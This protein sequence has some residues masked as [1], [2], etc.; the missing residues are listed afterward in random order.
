MADERVIEE[1]DAKTKGRP[2]RDKTGKSGPLLAPH[3]LDYLRRY[4]TLRQHHLDVTVLDGMPDIA[5]RSSDD[6]AL[7]AASMLP[8]SKTHVFVRAT[9]GVDI[10]ADKELAVLPEGHHSLVQYRL[11]EESIIADDVVLS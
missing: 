2:G 4:H 8:S 11:V 9:R 7:L 5:A 10:D 3:E 1:M 6:D